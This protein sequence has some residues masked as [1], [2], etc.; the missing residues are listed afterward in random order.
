MPDSQCRT[1]GLELLGSFSSAISSSAIE[2]A[3]SILSDLF[4]LCFHT[5]INNTSF[6][7]IFSFSSEEVIDFDVSF[8]SAI[9]H[10]YATVLNVVYI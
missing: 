10:K 8:F 2:Q 5:S 1:I 3:P 4:S 6:L 7:S 9:S